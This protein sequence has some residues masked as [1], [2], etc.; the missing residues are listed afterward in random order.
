VFEYEY[1][2]DTQ[3]TTAAVQKSTRAGG[4]KTNVRKTQETKQVAVAMR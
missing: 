1:G 4:E 2:T 3:H